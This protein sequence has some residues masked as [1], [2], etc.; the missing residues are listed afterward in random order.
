MNIRS[1]NDHQGYPGRDNVPANILTDY[2]ATEAQYRIECSAFFAAIFKVLRTSLK[3]KKKPSWYK[4][5]CE[6]EGS[7]RTSFFADLEKVFLQVNTMNVRYFAGIF[8]YLQVKNE[9]STTDEGS[10]VMKEHYKKLIASKSFPQAKK[11]EPRLV[12]ALDEAH[13]LHEINDLVPFRRATVLLQTI[14]EY[15]EGNDDAV[16]VVFASTTSKVA[17]FKFTSP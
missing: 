9:I 4:D 14:K 7:T 5:M 13:V 15:S 2:C 11:N 12:I 3:K 6:I 17:H 10:A 8:T 16:W 1:K